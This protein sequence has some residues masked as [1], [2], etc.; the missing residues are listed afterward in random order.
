MEGF[1]DDLPFCIITIA[2][3][4]SGV[5][6]MGFNRVLYLWTGAFSHNFCYF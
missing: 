3:R 6:V 2:D 4:G 1:F 5:I